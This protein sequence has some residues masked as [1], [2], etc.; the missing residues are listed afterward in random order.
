MASVNNRHQR[1]AAAAAI[2]DIDIYALVIYLS[3]SMS[4]VGKSELWRRRAREYMT[5]LIFNGNW[6]SIAYRVTS[7]AGSMN[8]NKQT[9]MWKARHNEHQT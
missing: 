1:M 3:I 9:V 6:Q 2:D 4:M 8:N 7:S 5:A